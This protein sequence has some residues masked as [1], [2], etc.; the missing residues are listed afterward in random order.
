MNKKILKYLPKVYSISLTYNITKMCKI[1]I[2]SYT[3]VSVSSDF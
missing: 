2:M 1:N 3:R